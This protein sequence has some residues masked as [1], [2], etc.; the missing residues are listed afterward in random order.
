MFAFSTPRYITRK[1]S[2]ITHIPF[3]FT[4]ARL[5]KPRTFVELGVYH[6]DS[7]CAFCQA[8]Q[9]LALGTQCTGVDTW[10]GDSQQGF[11]GHEV[12]ARLRA[13]HD[14]RYGAFSRLRQSTFDAAAAGFAEQSIDLLHIDGFHS[15]DA[16]RHD[17]DTWQPK[18]SNRAVVLF[19]DTAVTRPGYE[20]HRLWKELAPRFP[21]F[22]FRHG[23]GL[24][25][26]AVGQNLPPGFVNFLRN[27]NRLPPL[28]RGFYRLLGYRI[29]R[30]RPRDR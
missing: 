21:S 23:S 16:V 6:G 9:Q 14:P 12:L 7:Y 27:A 8:F 13:Y 5:L 28:Y 11:Y 22:A 20:V 17:F 30:L 29:R 18:L 1:S 10:T 4:L 3:A 19:H 24:G 26:L 2:W 15:Y 25:V